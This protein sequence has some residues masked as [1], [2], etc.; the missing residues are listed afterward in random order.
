[1]E[2]IQNNEIIVRLD[3]VTKTYISTSNKIKRDLFKKPAKFV[4]AL[5][6]VSLEVKSGEIF[7]LL[8]ANGSGKTTIIKLL[9]SLINKDSGKIEIFSKNISQSRDYLKD[10]GAIVEAPSMF[11][12]LTGRENLRYFA[13]LSGLHSEERIN[14]ILNIVGL[15]DRADTL[16]G[17]YSLGMQQRLGI[18]QAI[19]T[20]PKLLI[21]DE[22]INGLDPDGI[23][24]MRELM[25]K[26]NKTYGTT[27]IIS[28]HI[29]SEMQELCDR[30]AILVS[31]KIVAI[32]DL[33]EVVSAEQKIIAKIECS[34]VEKAF[35]IISAIDG[36]E[37]RNVNGVIYVRC[38]NDNLA[39]VNKTLIK[40]DI[41][42]YGIVIKKRTLEDIYKELA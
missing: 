14:D 13:A 31:G 34:N 36:V 6:N 40:N 4:T 37:V 41:N 26:L 24:Q 22:P 21:L 7:G 19:M 27:I 9:C 20:N 38:I 15:K 17:T 39:L 23:I 2:E 16:F 8:G 11:K 10:V 3:N 25:L 5:D 1:M 33:K 18:A 35:E 12:N 28:S 42:V 32:K 29:L 30:V